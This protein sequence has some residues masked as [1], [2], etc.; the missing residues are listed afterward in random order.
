MTAIRRLRPKA[1]FY[2]FEQCLIGFDVA[3]NTWI[4]TFTY[5]KKDFFS[6]YWLLVFSKHNSYLSLFVFRSSLPDVLCNKDFL[7]IS[8]NSKESTCAGVSFL[9]KFL[10][11]VKRRF[12]LMTFPFVKFFRLLMYGCFFTLFTFC[13]EQLL[14][15][16][17]WKS[18]YLLIGTLGFFTST[19][20]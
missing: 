6:D 15:Y 2:I 1:C 12:Q 16:F 9:V 3:K 20:F 18:Y 10:A 11:V 13:F 14:L 7:E 8:T 4:L 17:F 19:R 5:L